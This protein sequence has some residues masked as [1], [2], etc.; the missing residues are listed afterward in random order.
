MFFLIFQIKNNIENIPILIIQ[1]LKCATKLSLDLVTLLL[2]QID[3]K[4]LTKLLNYFS[5]LKFFR[6][7][8]L[9]FYF[10]YFYYYF[11]YFDISLILWLLLNLY[12]PV[13]SLWIIIFKVISELKKRKLLIRNINANFYNSLQLII[14]LE[15]F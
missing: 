13:N 3:I 4:I 2:K 7:M 1:N 5:W 10:H 8:S 14:S 9:F 11:Y 6:N 15:I 12:F